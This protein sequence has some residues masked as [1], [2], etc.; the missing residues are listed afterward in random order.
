MDILVKYT[1]FNKTLSQLKNEIRNEQ[2]YRYYR[3]LPR[4]TIFGSNRDTMEIDNSEG[5][6]NEYYGVEPMNY[7]FYGLMK[8]HQRIPHW[9]EYVSTYISYYCRQVDD[10]HMTF[11]SNEHHLQYVFETKKL[12]FKLI[13]AYMS[14]LKEVYVLFYLY[15]KGLH[16]IYYSM[17]MDLRG[18]DITAINRYGSMFGIRIYC[19]T[20]NAN[21]LADQKTQSRIRLPEGSTSIKLQADITQDKRIALGDTYIFSDSTLNSIYHYI[22]NNIQINY[23]TGRKEEYQ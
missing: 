20:D 10:T 5:G 11:K 3:S 18:F 23:D 14:F 6:R 22:N 1:D 8:K 21:N 17:E 19:K 2:Y 4:T 16:N 7:I 9:Q 13:R 15:E 12:E